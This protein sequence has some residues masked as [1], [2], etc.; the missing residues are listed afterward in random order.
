MTITMGLGPRHGVFLSRQRGFCFASV[1]ADCAVTLWA[2]NT[3]PICPYKPMS[4]ASYWFFFSLGLASGACSASITRLY[5]HVKIAVL[6]PDSRDRVNLLTKNSCL[7]CLLCSDLRLSSSKECPF[8][9]SIPWFCPMC[10]VWGVEYGA[11]F[12]AG[13]Y[14]VC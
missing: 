2:G 9:Q 3:M 5:L 6:V 4:M 11:I 13:S 8:N 7:L 12:H 14:S 10:R 1:W